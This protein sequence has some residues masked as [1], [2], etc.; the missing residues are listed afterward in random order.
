MLKN[1]FQPADIA[2][3][4]GPG[5]YSRGLA[6]YEQGRVLRAEVAEDLEGFVMLLA[7]VGGSRIYSQ[8]IAIS[9]DSEYDELDFDGHCS[10]PVGYNCKH[11]VAVCLDYLQSTVESD[12]PLSGKPQER[13]LDRWLGELASA[14]EASQLHP[15][16]ASEDFLIYLLAPGETKMGLSSLTVEMRATHPRKNG[17]GLVKGVQVS[18][19]SVTSNYHYSRQKWQQQTVDHDIARFLKALDDNYYYKR[20]VP[21]SGR[22]GGL[23]LSS[24]LQTGRCYWLDTDTMPLSEG[25]KR[26]LSLTWQQEKQGGDHNLTASIHPQASLLA[27]EPPM[28]IDTELGEIGLVDC[29]NLNSELLKSMLAAPP[30]PDNL[31]HQL[32]M[33]VLQHMPGLDIPLPTEINLC[34]NN[35]ENMRPWLTLKQGVNIQQNLHTLSLEFDYDGDRVMPFPPSESVLLTGAEQTVRVWRDIDS[36]RQAIEQL[37]DLGFTPFDT[38]PDHSRPFELYAVGSI[39]QSAAIWANFLEQKLDE[40]RAQG[41]HIEQDESFDLTFSEGDWEVAVEEGDEN[42][43]DWFGLRFDL[44]VDGE[45]LPLAPL[46]ASILEQDS[47]TLPETLTLQLEG[48][49][50][51]RLPSARIRPFLHTLRELFERAPADKDGL[52]RLPRFDATVIDEL[53]DDQRRIKG[54]KHLRKLSAR[55]QDFSGIKKVAVPN[56]FGAELRDYQRDGLNWLQFL[57]EYGFNGILADD[58]GLGKTVQTLAHLLVEKRSG[59]MSEPALIIAPTSLMGNWRREAEK[60][61]PELEVTVLHGDDR[62]LHFSA[63]KSSDIVL[64]TYPLL[65]RDSDV[66]L[67]HQ[68]HYVVLDEAQAIKNAKT[69]MSSLVREF[70]S[71]HRLCLTGTPLENHLGELWSLFDFLMP[72]FL[73]NNTQFTRSYR[74]PIEKHGNS[75]RGQSLARRVQPFLLRREKDAVAT[76]LPAKTE[77]IHNIE[78]GKEQAQF[79]ESIRVSMDKRVREVI[80][81]QGLARSHITILDA[82]LKLRQVCCD[83]RLTKLERGQR[84]KHSAKLEWLMTLLPE[85]L[86]EGRRILLFSQFTSMLGL[87]ETE[88]AKL[89]IAYTKLTG[90]TRKRDEAIQRFSQGEVNLFLISLKAG[91]TG[92]NLTEADTVII[93]DPWW[94]PAVESQAI[95]RAHRIGQDKPVFVYKLVTANSIEE[96]MLAMQARKRALADG[97]YSKKADA[98]ASLLDTDTLKELFAP[99]S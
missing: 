95:D 48:H 24:M 49:H 80:K 77:I 19:T 54:A 28:Y 43:N 22:V 55:L 25:E 73:G 7:T 74:T 94:N 15:A 41:W 26:Q 64:T 90:Q 63:I 99:L 69:K 53:G 86:E 82:L 47:E 87:I 65:S 81:E 9:Y 30:V 13:Q 79:Y 62:K 17:R 52:I 23:A 2:E 70:K 68:Y 34:E 31:A 12:A 44:N 20:S 1:F 84:L 93:Y 76:E 97:V 51:V 33:K 96:R 42:I 6:Y 91:G 35:G 59:R 3:A 89:D 88:L 11:V 58:M 8:D 61:A 36:E 75:E 5:A 83:P 39:V 60:F 66:L 27:T 18:A 85:Q 32:G 78:L 50:Y 57:R 92:L 37:I 67:D 21:L 29:G 14:V 10:C 46:L 56:G 40:L 4:C 71:Q 45:K 72:G 38:Q 98:E 16:S